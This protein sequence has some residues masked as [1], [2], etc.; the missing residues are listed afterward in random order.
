MNTTFYN[1]ER[2]FVSHTDGPYNELLR[3]QSLSHSF[4]TRRNS[5]SSAGTQKAYS[6]NVHQLLSAT[7]DMQYVGYEGYNEEC[8]GIQGNFLNQI[9][10]QDGIDFNIQ[11]KDGGSINATGAVLTNYNVSASVSEYPRHRTSF[12]VFELGYTT[13]TDVGDMEA[14]YTG[15]AAILP[16]NIEIE[17][18]GAC[19]IAAFCIQDFDLS[20]TVSRAYS[21]YIG[22]KIPSVK[23]VVFPVEAT[24][25]VNAYLSAFGEG[26]IDDYFTEAD[27][28]LIKI[29]YK[30][31]AGGNTLG[32]FQ[33]GNAF[34]VSQGLSNDTMNR[35]MLS[36]D[37]S[38]TLALA[39][40]KN[41]PM[42]TLYIGI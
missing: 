33:L 21:T 16:G 3:V 7:I 36:L 28:V 38:C 25:N 12:E 41:E 34:L 14:E 1:L 5:S 32:G 17:I 6:T 42:G 18:D 30:D 10:A 9:L 19:G 39:D 23:R 15:N 22:E 31:K 24:L 35:T 29:I 27:P 2:V 37:F 13:E 4:N 26:N 40:A 20:V 8:L 11:L